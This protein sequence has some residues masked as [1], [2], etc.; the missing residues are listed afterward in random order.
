MDESVFNKLNSELL[1]LTLNGSLKDIMDRT[2]A[3]DKKD[4]GTTKLAIS[5]VVIMIPLSLILGP[6]VI[7]IL[8][9]AAH[10]LASKTLRNENRMKE[11]PVSPAEE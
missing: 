2:L 7:I 11:E 9:L 1:E 4:C 6:V 5:P 3:G 8:G 10:Q